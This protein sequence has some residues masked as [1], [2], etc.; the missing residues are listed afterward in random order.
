MLIA[1]GSVLFGKLLD[2]LRPGLSHFVYGLQWTAILLNGVVIMLLVTEAAKQIRYNFGTTG[3]RFQ[4]REPVSDA[5]QSIWNFCLLCS[6]ADALS[7]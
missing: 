5:Q 2:R 4:E 7:N 3:A 6:K 1:S